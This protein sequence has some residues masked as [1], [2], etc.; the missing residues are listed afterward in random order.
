[1]KYIKYLLFVIVGVI[2]VVGGLL[3]YVVA[4]FNP[5]DYKSQLTDLVR[6]KTQ[7]TLTIEGDIKLH[8]FP[9]IGVGLGKTRLSEPRN[10]REFAAFTEA[11]VSL[12]VLPLLRKQVVVD[13]VALSG[14]RLNLLRRKDGKTNFDDLLRHAQAMGESGGEPTA[15]QAPIK[16]A[17]AGVAISDAALTWKD[18]QAGS[19]YEVTGLNLK[20]GNLGSHSASKIDLSM[21]VKGKPP[22]L[23][24]QLNLSG[25]LLADLEK[26]IFQVSGLE[27]KL[28]GDAADVTG[29]MASVSGDVE[30]QPNNKSAKLNGFK[31]AAAGAQGKNRFDVK[32]GM[33]KAELTAEN[34]GVN[35]LQLSAS[36]EF[37]G[38]ALTEATLKAASLSAGLVD[39]DQKIL[40]H[41]LNVAAKG[42]VQGDAFDAT[43]EA[44]RVDVSKAKVAA[45]AVSVRARLNGKERALDVTLK[46]SAAE[47]STKLLKLGDLSLTFD[48][49]QGTDA[50]KGT[51]T[52]PL[53]AS[54]DGQSVQLTKLVAEF[55]IESAKL[56]QKSI[57]LPLS[58]EMAVDALK[59]TFSANLATKFDESAIKAKLAL[60]N[61]KQ[62][63]VN[64][65]LSID[66]LNLDRYLPPAEKKK[67]EAVAAPASTQRE[68]PI[69]LAPLKLVNGTGTVRIGDLI[70]QRLKIANLSVEARLQDGK[71]DVS[72]FAASL[73][74]GSVG[75]TA[76]IDANGNKFAAK[77]NLVG[78]ALGP[79]LQDYLQKDL[80]EG[81]G[82]IAL[83]LTTQGN[84]PSALR[85]ALN[86]SAKVDLKNGAIKGIDLDEVLRNPKELLTRKDDAERGADQSKKTSFTELTA[87]F[88]IRNGIAHNEDLL[89]RTQALKLSGAGDIDVGEGSLNYLAK[90]GVMGSKGGEAKSAT[91]PVRISGPFD[92]M[93]FKLEL[94]ALASEAVK[95][96]VEKKKEAIKEKVKE[97]AT[98]K[99]KDKLK[100]LLKK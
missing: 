95:Q 31:F 63:N 99:A 55:N 24:L 49:K 37:N 20:T 90:A 98:E 28:S 64:F 2:V 36:G 97:Q 70:V 41:G 15:Q 46:L 65:D 52:T 56:P 33:S 80:A 10:E 1:M 9:R 19:E 6:G 40:L 82:N 35:D 26:N 93:K 87:S 69:D 92:A 66:K 38:I 91:L 51:L 59:Q 77:Q 53:N 89:A 74:Q 42:S 3:V 7:R 60:A 47:G 100:G 94:G 83:T 57:K 22:L 34:A 13:E 76:S 54:I 32:A 44:P 72:P 84:L 88:D 8:L 14:L 39:T 23:D 50:I 16:V 96:E 5:N 78:V 11:R 67:K 62:A 17:V 30:A 43:L 68:Q 21:H 86:G 73:Y 18:E 81:K 27:M 61:F 58:G 85:K 12:A 71:L 48:G 29:L 4:T 75:G 79:L 25:K 45:D